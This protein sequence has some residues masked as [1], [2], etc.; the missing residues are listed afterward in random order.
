MTNRVD[1]GVSA[2]LSRKAGEF[3]QGKEGSQVVMPFVPSAVHSSGIYS[4]QVTR[5]HHEEWVDHRD[6]RAGALGGGDTTIC[7][8]HAHMPWDIKKRD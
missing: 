1:K 3:L 4:K 8:R 7:G 2:I 5:A 6:W